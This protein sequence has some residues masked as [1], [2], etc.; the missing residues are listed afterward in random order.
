[1]SLDSF[2]LPAP[3]LQVQL[4]FY[5]APVHLLQCAHLPAS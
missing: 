2:T 3:L 5:F 1:M 4:S